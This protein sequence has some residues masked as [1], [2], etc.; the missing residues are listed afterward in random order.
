MCAGCGLTNIPICSTG[1]VCTGN[2]HAF[3]QMIIISTGVGSTSIL[4]WLKEKRKKK[5]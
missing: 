1:I 5:S 3:L 4:M 2:M